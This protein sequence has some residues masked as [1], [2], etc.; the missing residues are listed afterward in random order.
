[1]SADSRVA[2]RAHMLDM[3]RDVNLLHRVAVGSFSQALAAKQNVSC[4]LRYMGLAS[5]EREEL[6]EPRAAF[7]AHAGR[8][9]QVRAG[10]AAAGQ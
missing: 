4:G 7:E 10:A 9:L 5:A 8:L 2:W 1:M 6:A 3:Q